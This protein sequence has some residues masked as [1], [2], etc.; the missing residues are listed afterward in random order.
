MKE[1]DTNE[2]PR[3]V[4]CPRCG[5]EMPIFYEKK[6]E[7]DGVTVTC[8]GRNCHAVFQIKITSGEQIK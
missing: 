3:R 6:A 7:C 8:K 4:I 1:K 2:Y 5:Y